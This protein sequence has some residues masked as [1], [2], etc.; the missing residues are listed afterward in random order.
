MSDQRLVTRRSFLRIAG[1]AA[2]V[3]VLAG[4]MPAAARV[5][6]KALLPEM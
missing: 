2:G 3:A 6:E 4:C 1:G 5:V